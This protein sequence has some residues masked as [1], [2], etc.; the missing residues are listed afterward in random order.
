MPGCLK[1]NPAPERMMI[2]KKVLAA[3]IYRA[4]QFPS[5]EE[6]YR[7]IG[8]FRKKKVAVHCFGR[9]ENPDGSVILNIITAYN[10]APMY[11]VDDALKVVWDDQEGNRHELTFSN[12]EDARLEAEALKKKFDFVEVIPA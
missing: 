7:Y 3:G 8:E 9:I 10:Q 2:M 12:P 1:G 5:V 4:I 6:M 11:G